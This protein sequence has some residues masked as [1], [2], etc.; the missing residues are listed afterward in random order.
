[1]KKLI[2]AL[3]L[4]IFT[5]NIASAQ[6]ANSPLEERKITPE[7]RRKQDVPVG[8]PLQEITPQEREQMI[9]RRQQTLALL[10]KR[11]EGKTT[12]DTV[13]N[14]PFKTHIYTLA[15][16]LKV[17]LSVNKDAPRIQTMIAVK[18]GSKFD[19]AQTTGLA[20]YLEHMMFKGTKEFGT[21]NWEKESVLLDSISANFE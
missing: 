7:E 1:M 12:Y 15:N 11:N 21:K 17:Y 18:A 19:P 13:A 6:Q 20:H 14:D 10:D 2:I 16:G 5:G 4:A 3:S 9:A 8:R